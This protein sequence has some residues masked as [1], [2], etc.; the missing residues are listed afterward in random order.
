MTDTDYTFGTRNELAA[1]QENRSQYR[2]IAR[3]RLA[4]E[5]EASEPGS[6]SRPASSGRELVCGIR[7]I[8][9]SGLCVVAEENLPVGALFT[10][11][12]T[13]GNHEEPFV[14]TVEIV[15]C[16]QADQAY[17]VGMKIIESEQTAYVEWMD[18]VA[19]ALETP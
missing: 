14:L 18:A 3:A 11:L 19:S 16:R 9:A 12:V 8:S 5:L 10:A 13:L 15:W 7:D 17:T 1:G 4:L 6:G 2:L